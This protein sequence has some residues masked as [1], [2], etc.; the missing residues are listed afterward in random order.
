MQGTRTGGHRAPSEM[1][2]QQQQRHQ[3]HEHV[4]ATLES[5]QCGFA[6]VA[7]FEPAGLQFRIAMVVLAE[8]RDGGL[9]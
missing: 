3:H 5:A 4:V 1:Q 9:S 8:W 2:Q 7:P 6:H